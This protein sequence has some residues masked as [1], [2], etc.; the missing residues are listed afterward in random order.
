M[1]IPTQGTSG[2]LDYLV[3][4]KL[5]KMHQKDLLKGI[6]ALN[7]NQGEQYQGNT[8]SQ[9]LHAGDFLKNG[10]GNNI[11]RSVGKTPIKLPSIFSA[12]EPAQKELP[13]WQQAEEPK[14]ALSLDEPVI[15]KPELI[16]KK[17]PLNES[18]PEKKERLLKEREELKKNLA[19]EKEDHKAKKA[20]E[21]EDHKAKIALAQEQRAEKSKKQMQIDKE[22]LPYYKKMKEMAASIPE[23]EA[24]LDEM[25]ELLD[26]G[27]VQWFGFLDSLSRAPYIGPIAGAIEQAFLTTE[28]ALFK[29]LSTDFLRDAKTYF[30]SNMSTAEVKLFLERVPSLML[31]NEGNRALIRNMKALIE[32]SKEVDKI[33]EGV[34]AENG[35]ERPR[36]LESKVQSRLNPATEKLKKSFRNSVKLIPQKEVKKREEEAY[37]VKKIV[38]NATRLALP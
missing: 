20:L 27:N 13:T 12:T 26:T 22:T 16:K 23:V 4:N 33:L 21:K 8:L 2:I 6:M 37:G 34:I 9:S 24:R 30:G 31:T 18:A 17:A 38:N 14:K 15:Q 19:I 3:Q 36:H 1:A 35:G 28:S 32:Y 11:E 7:H 25:E 29:K 10:Q 5:Q